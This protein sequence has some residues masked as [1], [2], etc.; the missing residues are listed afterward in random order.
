MNRRVLRVDWLYLID[1]RAVALAEIWLAPEVPVMRRARAE[2]ISTEDMMRGAGI[3]LASSEMSIRSMSAGSRVGRL[4]GISKD[5]PILA[6]RRRALGIDGATKEVG[7]FWI[8]SERY[9]FVC[10]THAQG[11]GK[12]AFGIRKLGAD[13]RPADMAPPERQ[14]QPLR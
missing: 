4:L 6:V 10:S 2:L 8:R 3:Q 7:S 11:F 1:G 14:G 12:R 9:E 13:A 5:A